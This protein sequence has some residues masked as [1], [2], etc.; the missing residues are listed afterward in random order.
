MKKFFF[1][2]YCFLFT[3]CSLAQ[4]IQEIQRTNTRKMKSLDSAGWEKS[5]FFIFNL[6][7]A[8]LSDWSSGGER[9]L[10]GVNGI[11]NYALHHHKGKFSKHSYIDI[12]LG[13]VEA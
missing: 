4:N 8:A 6:N 5:G 2:T 10:I 13:A 12:E 7:Q 9:F 3:F 11:F 1:L